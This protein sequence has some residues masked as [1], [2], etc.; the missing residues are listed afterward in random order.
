M[1]PVPESGPALAAF[2]LASG[3]GKLAL[4]RTAF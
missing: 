2:H 3:F 1:L 4:L